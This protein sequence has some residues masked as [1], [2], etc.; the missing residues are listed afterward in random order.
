MYFILFFWHRTLR[1]YWEFKN[2]NAIHRKFV[3]CKFINLKEVYQLLIRYATRAFR[4][5]SPPPP[6]TFFKLTATLCLSHPLM[7]VHDA[8]QMTSFVLTIVQSIMPC[9][10]ISGEKVTPVLILP[11]SCFTIAKRWERQTDR[12]TKTETDREGDGDTGVQRQ[13][14]REGDRW[15]RE[16]KRE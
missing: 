5:S 3:P 6:P 7:K 10:F 2:K 13:T 14:V 1:F 9:L 12:W 11:P 16:V 8:H 4:L 15:D